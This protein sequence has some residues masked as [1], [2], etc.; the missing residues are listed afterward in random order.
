MENFLLDTAGI[1]TRL[2]DLAAKDAHINA[3][4]NL[5]GIPPERMGEQ[6]FHTFMR[7]IVGQQLSVKAAA[8]IRD[9]VEKLAG[10]GAG[11]TDYAKLS[12]EDLRGAGLSR[13]KISYARS[14]CETVE[15]GTLDIAALPHMSNEDAIAAITAV[16]GLGV[17]SA[18]MYLMF[19]LGRDDIWPVGD[20]A[21]RVGVGRIIGLEERPTEK[22]CET[23]GER[24]RPYRSVVALLA[25]HYYSNAPAI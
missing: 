25:W 3:A 5:V 14:L 17:W 6:G 16:K 2:R 19:S 18:H 12:D 15:A 20:L 7:V 13:Q 24:W 1:E 4:I 23:I 8:T 11:P 9:R 21:V 22:E 10:E